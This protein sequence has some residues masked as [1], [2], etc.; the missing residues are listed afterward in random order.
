M[1]HIDLLNALMKGELVTLPLLDQ[2]L[3]G[4]QA[5]ILAKL[6]PERAEQWLKAGLPGP[7]QVFVYFDLCLWYWDE[8]LTREAAEAC[9]HSDVTAEYWLRRGIAIETESNWAEAIPFYEMATQVEPES[10][11]AWHRLGT[12]LVLE[13]RYEEAILAFQQAVALGFAAYTDLGQAYLQTGNLEEAR[14][15]LLEGIEIYPESQYAYLYLGQIAETQEDWGD[16]DKWYERLAQIAP[17]YGVAYSAR[18]RIAVRLGQYEQAVLYFQQATQVEPERIGNWLDLGDA[19]ARAHDTATAR[20]A[21][22]QALVLQ[23]DNQQAQA[24][25]QALGQP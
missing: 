7:G 16:A 23:P 3:T 5:R 11:K 4:L 21:Y 22:Q 1:S 14:K 10:G 8:G 18:G 24:G 13:Q 20:T 2:P 15:V 12:R 19:A 17:G 25:L 6:D 9:R